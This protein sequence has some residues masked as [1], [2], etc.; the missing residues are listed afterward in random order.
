MGRE[1]SAPRSPT[2]LKLCV[3]FGPQKHRNQDRSE[4]APM[5]RTGQGTCSGLGPRAILI[6]SE[7]RAPHTGWGCRRGAGKRVQGAGF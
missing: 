1:L 5:D 7:N 2:P 6:C 4:A 3:E